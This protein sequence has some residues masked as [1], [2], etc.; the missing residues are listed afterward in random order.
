MP[1]RLSRRIGETIVV[2]GPAIIELKSIHRTRV[3]VVVSAPDTTRISR[4]ERIELIESPDPDEFLKPE[5]GEA[6]A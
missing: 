3:V 1:L 2:D 4:G 5:L 6:G